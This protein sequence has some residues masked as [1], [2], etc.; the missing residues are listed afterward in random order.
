MWP[1]TALLVVSMRD[2]SR[3]EFDVVLQEIIGVDTDFWRNFVESL[4]D[5][6]EIEDPVK[7]QETS[8]KP[9]V[10][11]NATECDEIT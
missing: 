8:N 10:A 7:G 11:T 5:H 3:S 1:S 4:R 6:V 9:E 2:L